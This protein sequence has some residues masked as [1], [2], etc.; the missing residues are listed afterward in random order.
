LRLWP[1][2]LASGVWRLA[3][4]GIK[5]TPRELRPKSHPL[6][7]IRHSNSGPGGPVFSWQAVA[8]LDSPAL[9]R[10]HPR[11]SE[12][13]RI[14]DDYLPSS[15]WPSL[16]SR[17]GGLISR[18]TSGARLGNSRTSSSSRKVTNHSRNLGSQTRTRVPFH[19]LHCARAW[20]ETS[21]R[22]TDGGKLLNERADRLAREEPQS[23]LLDPKG[24]SRPGTFGSSSRGRDNPQPSG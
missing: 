5:K 1:S 23:L 12:G 6:G 22:R 7:V 20:R 4:S 15:S 13:E 11:S 9:V 14:Q 16:I 19:G 24:S 3:S 2:G 21:K 18:L 17:A 8:S 10:S